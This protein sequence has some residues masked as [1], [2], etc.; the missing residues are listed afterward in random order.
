MQLTFKHFSAAEQCVPFTSS[1]QSDTDNAECAAE[2]FKAIKNSNSNSWISPWNKKPRRHETRLKLN[3]C[4]LLSLEK[5]FPFVLLCPL[6]I[7]ILPKWK[8]RKKSSSSG[9]GENCFPVLVALYSTNATT[10]RGRFDGVSAHTHV[11]RVG[12]KGAKHSRRRIE[13]KVFGRIL[14]NEKNTFRW[15]S[16]G[17]IC[18]SSSRRAQLPRLHPMTVLF[19]IVKIATRQCARHRWWFP[20]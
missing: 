9:P 16:Q 10:R 12:K 13:R 3:F 7:L 11:R 17:G 18:R 5:H 2:K 20:A 1:Q 19:Q 14:E 8:S 4:S 6:M 15:S